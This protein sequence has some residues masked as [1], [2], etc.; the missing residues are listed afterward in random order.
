M[1]KNSNIFNYLDYR[2]YLRDALQELKSNNPAYTYRT[3]AL[4]L[5]MK[6]IGHITWILQGKR[7]ITLK[8]INKFEKLLNLNKKE[9]AYFKT[10]VQFNNSKKHIDK[11]ILFEK[12]VNCQ[13]SEKKI[14]SQDQYTYWDKWYNSA[15]RELVSLFEISDN[16]KDVAKLLIPKI[17]PAEAEHAMALLESLGL[18]EK[19]EKG[20]YRRVDKIV[21]TGEGWESIAIRQFQMEFLDLAKLALERIPKEERDIS[22]LT[23]SVS[24]ERFETIRTMIKDLRQ[25]I[26]TLAKTDP[27]PQRIYQIGL[28]VFPLSKSSG[29]QH[30]E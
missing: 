26:I 20:S 2:E 30:D 14:I 8:N 29:E 21:T 25:Q 4:E 5:G 3:I 1:N 23:I 28:Q 17:S 24:E 16:Y 11:K 10:I 15:I 12:I 22:S 6:S 18:I 13:K 27:S 9:A 7:N 19:N